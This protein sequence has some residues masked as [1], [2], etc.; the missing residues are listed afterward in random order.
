[1]FIGQILQHVNSRGSLCVHVCLRVCVG[2]WGGGGRGVEVEGGYKVR[3]NHL[4]TLQGVE[5]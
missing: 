2:G 3:Y 5:V 4:L 1:M